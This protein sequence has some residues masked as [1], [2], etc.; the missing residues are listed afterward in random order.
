MLCAPVALLRE[1]GAPPPA[2][3]RNLPVW[4]CP[5]ELRS[6]PNRFGLLDVRS[7]RDLLRRCSDPLRQPLCTVQ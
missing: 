4:L 5:D 7:G 1:A 3:L 2:Q 6:V